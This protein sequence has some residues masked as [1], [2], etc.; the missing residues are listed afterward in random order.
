MIPI[1]FQVDSDTHLEYLLEIQ[2]WSSLKGGVG[3][4]VTTFQR[5]RTHIT[6]LESAW[7][8]LVN[9]PSDLKPRYLTPSDW[10]TSW[11]RVHDRSCTSHKRTLPSKFPIVTSLLS[12]E[13]ATQ[14]QV[15]SR[16]YLLRDDWH[17]KVPAET[18][19]QI[20][21]V[22]SILPVA[23]LVPLLFHATDVTGRD[24]PVSVTSTVEV[25]NKRIFPLPH[26][27]RSCRLR[28][29][30][31]YW[32]RHIVLI[33]RSMRSTLTDTQRY[34]STPLYWKSS[35]WNCYDHCNYYT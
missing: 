16:V 28:V 4:G 10:H 21:T 29:N 27:T 13:K 22:L 15:T 30:E 24:W 8:I 25:P 3:E 32:T 1:P 9:R 34:Q 12:G 19:D 17:S 2:V 6:K 33:R 5:F 11:Q 35:R 26:L 7:Q 31:K 20:L 14:L 18:T 23:S